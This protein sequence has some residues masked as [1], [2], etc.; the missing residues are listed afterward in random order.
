[1]GGGRGPSSA[2]VR[3]PRRRR[4]GHP[5]VGSGR[6]D[7]GSGRGAAGAAAALP[8]AAPSRRAA[9]AAPS[10]IAPSGHRCCPQP[11]TTAGPHCR[12]RSGHGCRI[13]RFPTLPRRLHFSRWW[14]TSSA[15]PRPRRAGR[16]L[17]RGRRT[18][19]PPSLLAAGF[20]AG[21]LRWRRG[22]GEGEEARAARVFAPRPRT[23]PA[24]ALPWPAASS[25]SFPPIPHA[26]RTHSLPATT[27]DGSTGRASRR[28]RALSKSAR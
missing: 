11:R 23:P 18:S 25:S 27:A 15:S 21:E 10:C 4:S 16:E 19:P 5:G 22:G 7:A 2:A 12:A 3:R 26:S 28:R 14:G 8:G 13:R 6:E 24:A 20:A 17:P 1:M 9:T